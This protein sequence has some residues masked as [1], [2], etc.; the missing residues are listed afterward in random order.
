MAKTKTPV[1]LATEFVTESIE[2]A[3]SAFAPDN[4]VTKDGMEALS[5]SASVYQ[6]RFA[7]LQLKGVEYAEANAKAAFAFWRDAFAAKS[8]DALFS[9]QQAFVKSQSEILVRQ[10]QDI[11]TLAMSLVRDAA[12]PVQDNM[13]KAFSAFQ[14]KKAA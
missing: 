3:K 12:Q 14:P 13:S 4:A 10:F 8:P 2:S 7:D 9:L 6:T 5:K 1:E 11:N